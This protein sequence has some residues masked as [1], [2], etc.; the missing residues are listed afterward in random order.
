MFD[1]YSQNYQQ[2]FNRLRSRAVTTYEEIS[3]WAIDELEAS[4]KSEARNVRR[5][6]YDVLNVMAAVGSIVKVKKQVFNV[7]LVCQDEI[8][9][10]VE[11]RETI[12]KSIRE[13]ERK[14]IRLQSRAPLLEV[15]A[16]DEL[17]DD[18]DDMSSFI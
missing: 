11:K 1:R 15:Q 18:E 6:A 5:R 13:K 7:D 4:G 10:L 14:L 17:S 9:Q 8:S 2:V 12:L 3:G 16:R